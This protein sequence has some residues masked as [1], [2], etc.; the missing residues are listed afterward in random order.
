MEVMG[1]APFCAHWA[2]RAHVGA[3]GGKFGEA[4]QV[5]RSAWSLTLNGA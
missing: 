2:G 1:G 4:P 5:T 3:S